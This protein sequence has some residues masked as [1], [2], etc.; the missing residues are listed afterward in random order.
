MEN[1]SNLDLIL[2]FIYFIILLLVLVGYFSSKKQ[3]SED[4]LIGKRKLGVLSTMM[5]LNASKTGSIIMISVALVY[6]WGI[7]ALWYFIGAIIGLLIFLPFALKLKENSKQ[8]FY[9]LADYFKYNYGKLPAIFASLITIFLMFGYLVMNLMAGTK[10]FVFFTG[11]PFVLCA[12][13]MVVVVLF[14]LLMGGFKAVVKTDIIQYA[15]MFLILIILVFSIFKGSTIP[16]SEWNILKADI[17][18]MIG[19]FVVGILIPFAMPDLW[20]RVYAAKDKKAFKRGTLVSI[21][22]YMIFAFLLGLIALTVKINFPDIDP[23]LALIYGFKYLLPSGLLGLSIILLFAAIMSSVDTYF[24]TGS[25]AIVQDFFNFNKEKTVKN[26]KKTI[27]ILAIFGTLISILIQNLIIST[28]IFVSLVLVLASIVVVTWIRK[29][30]KPLTLTIAFIIGTI[31]VVTLIVYYMFFA[32]GIIPEI[33][34]MG[35]LSVII[36]LIIGGLVSKIKQ[37]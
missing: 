24:F 36:S 6:V 20:R 13:I 22:V 17:M 26:I 28:Y 35:V 30:I 31:L 19:F 3:T 7:A 5:T 2:I 37:R 10:I 23:D 9:T 18:T 15:A 21:V 33:A 25:S 4:Y 16:I 1:L 29:K 8:R 11:W 14:Y 32:G 12:L 27:F 34:I